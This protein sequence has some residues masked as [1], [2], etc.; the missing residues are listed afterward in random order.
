MN[1]KVLKEFLKIEFP[2][3]SQYSKTIGGK[4]VLEDVR[5]KDQTLLLLII[6]RGLG[7]IP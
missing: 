5:K 4:L 1:G 6:R 3:F 2:S 7:F